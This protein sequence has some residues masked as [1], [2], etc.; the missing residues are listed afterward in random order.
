MSLNYT[1]YVDQLSNLM[2]QGSTEANFLTFLPGCIDYAE[3]RIYRELDLQTT[4]VADATTTV[5]SGVR[6]FTIPTTTPNGNFVVVEQINILTPVTATSSYGTRNPLTLV[7]KEYLDFAWPSAASNTGVPLFMAPLNQTTF[8][9]G[10]APDAAYTAEVVGTIRPLPLSASNS[11]T[12]LTQNLPDVF[13]AASMVFATA[14]QRNFGAMADDPAQGVTW[15]G[16]YKTLMASANIEELRKR[17]MG[18]AWQPMTPSPVATP[19]R[20]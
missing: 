3:Q 4:R 11:S 15:E 13:M 20:V 2:V 18:P 17:F 14:Y 12:F 16:Q 5:S 7:T 10:P 9:F 6:N 8:I 1:T 19:P